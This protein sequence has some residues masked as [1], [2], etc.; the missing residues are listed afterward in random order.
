MKLRHISAAVFMMFLP[1]ASYA[2]QVNLVATIKNGPAMTP[3]RWVVKE[4]GDI[5]KTSRSHSLNFELDAG[6][7]TATVTRGDIVRSRTFTVGST[8]TVTVVI[9]VD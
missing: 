6:T 1:I 7:Y 3:V 4:S 9:A 5:V 2:G 8:G